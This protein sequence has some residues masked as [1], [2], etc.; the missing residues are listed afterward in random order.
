LKAESQMTAMPGASELSPSESLSGASVF[1][2]KETW[3]RLGPWPEWCF[4]YWEDAAWCR[5]ARSLGMR[6]AI[7]D[8]AVKHGR[9]TTAGRR[10]PLTVYYGTRNQLLLH[11][12][13]FPSGKAER[14]R[15]AFYGLQKRLFRGRFRELIPAW[16]GIQDALASHPA[17]GRNPRY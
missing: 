12:E 9:G 1:I 3:Q 15:I 7:L 6:F 11:R 2:S 13:L 10:S 14:R 8:E 16:R 5:Q 17:T 4:L